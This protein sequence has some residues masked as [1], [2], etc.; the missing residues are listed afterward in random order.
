[1]LCPTTEYAKLTRSVRNKHKL[2]HLQLKQTDQQRA[3]HHPLPPCGE[4]LGM[5]GKRR[6]REKHT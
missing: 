5:G 1:M 6:S 3:V 4:G 2:L